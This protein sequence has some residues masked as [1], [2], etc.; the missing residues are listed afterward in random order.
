ME[1]SKEAASTPRDRRN[2]SR[3]CTAGYGALS[4]TKGGWM[5]VARIERI[6]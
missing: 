4:W 6:I 2:V 5:S 1:W 3:K